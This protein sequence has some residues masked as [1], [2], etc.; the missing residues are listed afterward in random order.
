MSTSSS[1]STPAVPDH[2]PMLLQLNK[3][4]VE[5]FLEY[6]Q[7]LTVHP[8]PNYDDAVAFLKQM[9]IGL[10]MACKVYHP[11][12]PRNP[13]VIMSWVGLEPDLPSILLNSHMDVV[14][15]FE[16]QWTNPPFE[17]TVDEKGNIFARGSQDMKCVGIQYLEAIRRMRWNHKKIK[18][19]I[20]VSFVPDEELSGAL[21][22][23]KF[24][25][26]EDFKALNVGFALDEG[27]ANPTRHFN[28]FYGERSVWKIQV[29]CPGGPGHASLLID[30][31]PGQKLRVVI[32]KFLDF[33]TEQKARLLDPKVK[34][35]DVTSVNLTQ[36][37]GG[38]Q[39]NVIPNNITVTFD[40]RLSSEVNHEDFEVMLK[41]WC[42]EAGEGVHYTFLTKGNQVENTSV[43]DTNPYWLAFKRACDEEKINLDIGIFPAATD[44][45]YIRAV[46]IPAIGFSPM[47]RTKVL[48]HDHDEHLNVKV[49]LRG[50]DIYKRIIKNLAN[51]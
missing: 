45:R 37:S 17:P 38:N 30:N 28:V 5:N 26:T 8:N 32:D 42:A 44:S 34:L 31:T 11:A 13:V 33:R 29:H 49:F 1:S 21:G 6:L 9:A 10:G 39:A 35:G 20:H 25:E 4:A 2:D 41:Q 7:I 18:R 40:V 14:P 23:E 50:I 46:G 43:D 22:M 19:T 47:N 16:D 24:V 15:A 27:I 3:M 48:L 36:I 12:D 51:F